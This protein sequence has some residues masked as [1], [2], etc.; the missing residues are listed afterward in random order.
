[1]SDAMTG[2][3]TGL[4]KDRPQ[5]ILSPAC[6]T[7]FV[8]EL[9]G[10][11]IVCDPC[12]AHDE[13]DTV[14]AKLRYFGGDS[15]NGLVIDWPDKTYVNS[16]FKDLK[17]WLAKTIEEAVQPRAPR[18][19][20][21]CPVRTNRKWFRSARNLAHLTGAVVELDPF[22]F[23]GFEKGTV[24]PD[25]SVQKSNE[26]FPPSACLLCFN[27]PRLDAVMLTAK[28]ALGEIL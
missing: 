7:G 16:P 14:R 22:T 27:V 21:L 19:A 15:D 9:F 6:I 23:V 24:K 1:M 17:V 18:I 25:G 10:G 4:K 26:T 12:A 5:E 11:E 28:H 8:R 3:A 2:L 13:R 20:V